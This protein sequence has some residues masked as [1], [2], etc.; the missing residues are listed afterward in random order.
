MVRSF[1]YAML[2]IALLTACT[3]SQQ[4]VIATASTIAAMS[5][6]LAPSPVPTTTQEPGTVIFQ[7]L[8]VEPGFTLY[9][10]SE[11]VVKLREDTLRAFMEFAGYAPTT[12]WPIEIV[13][14]SDQET[15]LQISQQVEATYTITRFKISAKDEFLL[16]AGLLGCLGLVRDTPIDPLYLAAYGNNA[17]NMGLVYASILSDM[18][19]ED[20]FTFTRD[21]QRIPLVGDVGVSMETKWVEF[22]NDLIKAEVKELPLFIP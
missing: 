19:Y 2:I 5:I 6:P 22:H 1:V 4:P 18:S 12:L 9:N 21:H 11:Q 8:E 20:Y 15:I 14:V 10:E 13:I 7:K 3:R 16:N 17:E